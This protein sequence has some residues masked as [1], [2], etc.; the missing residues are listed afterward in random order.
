MKMHSEAKAA[1]GNSCGFTDLFFGINR[2]RLGADCSSTGA[3]ARV[4][5][6][7]ESMHGRHAGSLLAQP[8]VAPGPTQPTQQQQSGLLFDGGRLLGA[9]R[10]V[11]SILA[12]SGP[13][14]RARS[15][16]L[17]PFDTV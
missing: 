10:R 9:K 12:G 16:G 1:F 11:C 4:G 7:H 5:R 17:H 8:V 6:M 2:E 3:A 13:L 15:K 14:Q